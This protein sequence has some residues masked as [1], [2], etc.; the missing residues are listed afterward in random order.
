MAFQL[1]RILGQTLNFK[2]VSFKES[3]IKSLNNLGKKVS[4]NNVY[5]K[6]QSLKRRARHKV[7]QEKCSFYIMHLGTKGL[8]FFLQSFHLLKYLHQL[9][10][11]HGVNCFA[12][13][14]H[15]TLISSYFSLT[16]SKIE[17]YLIFHYVFEKVGV[18]KIH[19][20]MYDAD[21]QKNLMSD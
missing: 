12:L 10:F 14:Q 2:A 5:I 13:L 17:C 18:S 4:P 16:E 19:N 7:K 8:K 1:L 15:L 6:I 3:A 20:E 9:P 21:N 11:H